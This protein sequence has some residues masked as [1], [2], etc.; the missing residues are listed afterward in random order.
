VLRRT[1]DTPWNASTFGVVPGGFATY[2]VAPSVAS[3]SYYANTIGNNAT[4]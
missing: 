1:P 2:T 3:T 4:P